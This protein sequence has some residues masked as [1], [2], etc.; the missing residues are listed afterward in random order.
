MEEK[1]KFNWKKLIADIIKV[2]L[3]ALSGWLGAGL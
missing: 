2:A 1:S 3:G